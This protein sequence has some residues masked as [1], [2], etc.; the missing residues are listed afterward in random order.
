MERLNLRGDFSRFCFPR[1]KNFSSR[2]TWD[3]I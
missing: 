2:K 1:L 3:E